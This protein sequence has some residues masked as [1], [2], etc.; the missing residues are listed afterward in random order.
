M[1][2]RVFFPSSSLKEC[3]T[4]AVQTVLAV[5]LKSRLLLPSAVAVLPADS[6]S[7]LFPLGRWAVV[8]GQGIGKNSAEASL[9]KISAVASRYQKFNWNF[10]STLE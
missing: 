9:E 10:P 4:A 3:Y 5:S 7:V 8:S 2:P 6:F 1:L